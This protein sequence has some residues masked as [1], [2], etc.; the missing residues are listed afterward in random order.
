M[1]AALGDSHLCGTGFQPVEFTAN[2]VERMERRVAELAARAA[3][4]RFGGPD[5]GLVRRELRATL[6]VLRHACRRARV[7]L[8]LRNGHGASRRRGGIRES[9]DPLIRRECRSLAADMVRIM[10][11]HRE[12]WMARNR[13]GGLASSLAYYRRNLREYQAILSGRPVDAHPSGE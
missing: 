12:L 8:A 7:M 10:E 1:Q 6:A 4:A 5:G 11:R 13:R 3:K 2:H 9:F